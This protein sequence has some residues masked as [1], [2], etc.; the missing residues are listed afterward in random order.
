MS[1]PWPHT[2][3]SEFLKPNTRP[4]ALGPNEDANLVGMRWYGEGPF[5]RELKSAMKIAKKSH[6]VIRTGDII[7]NKLFAWK[8]SFGVVPPALD[9]MFVSDK[10]PTYELDR[11]K[12]DE[13]WLRWFF[14][15]PP[16]WEQARIM[17]KGSAALS[18]LTLNP[19]KFLHLKMPLPHID[20]QRELAAR[21]DGLAA[22]TEE[23]RDLQD[24]ALTESANLLKTALRRV[25]TNVNAIGQLGQVLTG[26]PRNG[27]SAKCDNA[28]GGIPVL[29][30]GAVTGFRYRATEFKKTSLHADKDG[31]FWLKQGDLLITRSNTP[32][33]VG[34]AAIYSGSP[35][36]CIYPD[37]MMRLP[38]DLERVDPK[39]VWYW[40]QSP[41]ARDFVFAKAK[42]TSSTMK[43]ISQGIV[44]AIPFPEHL[45]LPEQRRIV[46]ELDRLQTE[47]D[48]LRV[49]QVETG[50]ELR[51]LMPSIVSTTFT[52]QLVEVG[53]LKNSKELDPTLVV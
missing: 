7:Y 30:L 10:F 44:M 34:H 52:G 13:N 24:Q 46:A 4:Y 6:F 31:H 5:H 17:S 2:S 14:R 39:F 27:W 3:F 50:M 19:P 38:L 32:E 37:L 49:F 29:S 53:A 8:G 9:G 43:K 47:V 12:V 40:L 42:G 21:L 35:S 41:P 18:M 48:S 26:K 33:L 15:W 45:G 11:S 51:A 20:E 28:E 22:K 25:A 36:P 23:A 1:I 16:L